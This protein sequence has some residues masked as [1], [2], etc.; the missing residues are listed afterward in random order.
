MSTDAPS[1]TVQEPPGES[2]EATEGAEETEQYEEPLPSFDPRH[3]EAFKGLIY[4]GRLE[5][6]FDW[7]GHHFI[8]K[9][10][11]VDELLI[12][13]VVHQPYV[14]TLS[15]MRA[16]QAAIA[17]AC[18]VSIDGEP[19]PLPIADD[20][21]APREALLRERFNYVRKNWFTPTLDIIYHEY[22]LL[23]TQVEKV[24]IAMGE[25]SG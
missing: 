21:S 12:V 19:P 5:R 10:L 23:E 25:A 13:G 4:L 15:E 8:L 7:M 14:G 3:R 22:L 17:A 9:T 2:T 24:L 18:V 6:E 20:G 16:Y 11:S 1:A